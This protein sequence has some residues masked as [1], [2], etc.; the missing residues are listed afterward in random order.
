VP[1][2]V[3]VLLLRLFGR[4]PV[5]ARR[6]VIRLITPSFTVGANCVIERDDGAVLL[7]RQVYRS[8]WGLPGGLL[9]RGEDPAAAVVREVQEE[10]G[11]AVDIVGEPAVVVDAEA[12][13]VD[14]VY[15]ARPAEVVGDLSPVSPEIVELRWHQPN[16]LPELQEEAAEALMTLA[17]SA[18]G[19][20]AG[21]LRLLGG[22]EGGPPGP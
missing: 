15:R 14:V 16:E 12:R 21:R 7:V 1:P 9:E 8:R 3:H 17:R 10:V 4:L 2:G 18:T 22:G 11:L 20:L 19:D 13:R 5:R 6:S